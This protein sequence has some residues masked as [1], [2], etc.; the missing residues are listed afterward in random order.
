MGPSLFSLSMFK[1]LNNYKN[2][3]KNTTCFGLNRPS[4]G[5]KNCLLR[6]LLILRIHAL[7][8]LCLPCAC[9]LL[10]SQARA[11]WPVYQIL[12]VIVVFE[13]YFVSLIPR[14]HKRL[15]T[16]LL[17]EECYWALF[18]MPCIGFLHDLL[19]V[20]AP[21]ANKMGLQKKYRMS[22]QCL[23]ANVSRVMTSTCTGC[24]PSGMW[25]RHS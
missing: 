22:G 4:S 8:S 10:L 3:K 6:K 1:T 11:K 14:N 19:N 24:V 18:Y 13:V 9:S 5:V 7:S 17:T 21:I 15:W 25:H 23:H 16:Y 12:S 2:L 20:P